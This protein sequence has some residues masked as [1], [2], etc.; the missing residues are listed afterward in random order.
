[1]WD[2]KYRRA[3]EDRHFTERISVVRKKKIRSRRSRARIFI[4]ISLSLVWALE[5][6]FLCLR[7][8]LDS[9]EWSKL[10]FQT[11]SCVFKSKRK[12]STD[13][14]RKR[15][16]F[17]LF[18]RNFCHSLHAHP[19]KG[20]IDPSWILYASISCSKLTIRLWKTIR[21]R[22]RTRCAEGKYCG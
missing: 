16:P 3:K 15:N 5:A 8:F 7:W 18:P 4:D 12:R 6:R 9:A 21:F 2:L 19:S 1:M 17:F 20:Y 10:N 22:K 14:L 11:D 13:L